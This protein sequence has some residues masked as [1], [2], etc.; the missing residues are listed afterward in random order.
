M[1]FNSIQFIIFFIVVTVIYFLLPYKYR[2]LFLLVS[3]CAFYMAW[4]PIFIVLI[5]FSTA[6]NYYLSLKINDEEDMS[7]KKLYLNIALF[8]SF[9]IL[10]LFKY[11][12]LINETFISIFSYANIKY[13]FSTIDILLPM[14]ISFYTFQ[15][16][17]YTIDVYRGIV[18]PEKAFLRLT[19]F[20]TFFPQLVAGPIERSDRL[21]PQLFRKRKFRLARAVDGVQIMIFGYFKKVVIADRLSIAVNTVYNN[22]QNYSGLYFFIATILFAFQIY[23]D[24]SAYSEIALGCAKVLGIE[25]M[26]NFQ[27]PY[28][29]KSI[30]E[31]WKRWHI[32]LSTWF[33]DYLYIPLGGNRLGVPRKYFNL[34]ITFLASGLWHGAN[35]TFVIWGM[36]HGLY[37]IIGDV[38]AG[39]REKILKV[40][41]LKNTYFLKLVQILTT[42][43]LVCFAWIFFR[44][45]SIN[46]AIYIIKNLFNDISNWLTIRYIYDTVTGMGL[47]LLEFIIA[48]LSI[49]ILI[50]CEFCERKEKLQSRLNRSSII[51][52]GS[53]YIFLIIIILTMGVYHNASQFIYFQF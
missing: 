53:F 7:K 26:E 34:I 1:L 22:P 29:S 42:F 2:W 39:I 8:V 47:N 49:L 20:V 41:G 40:T 10:F 43:S 15:T 6:V 5:L 17:S 48:I 50:I 32:S 23:C 51:V 25:L 30:K 21:L 14:G 18:K 37:Q 16:L 31:F 38:S 46:D 9:G 19:L 13:P 11:L 35:W 36:L 12:T 24:F 3:S 33:K 27:R 44:A 45:N 52:N 4:K 28:F